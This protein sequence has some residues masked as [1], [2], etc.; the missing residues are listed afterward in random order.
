MIL[1]SPGLTLHSI[2]EVKLQGA[3]SSVLSLCYL[4]PSQQQ[5]IGLFF[6]FFS[7][8]PASL[9]WTQKG[10]LARSLHPAIPSNGPGCKRKKKAFEF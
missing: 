6:P 5:H 8:F 4:T 9:H 1:G 2:P 7:S 3:G 10:Q